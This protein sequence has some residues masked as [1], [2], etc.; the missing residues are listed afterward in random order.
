MA[1]SVLS[2]RR[3][4][5]ARRSLRTRSL[6]FW[7]VAR[8]KYLEKV[9]S[10]IPTRGNRYAHEVAQDDLF[11]QLLL[12]CM[13]GEATPTLQ[14]VP[15]IDLDEY[16]HTLIERFSNGHIRDTL[17]RLC[18]E[19][20]DRIPTWLL[21]VIRINLAQGGEVR[22]ST[23]MRSLNGRSLRETAL[24]TLPIVT[25]AVCAMDMY[26]VL[27][28]PQGQVFFLVSSMTAMIFGVAAF[29]SASVG[30]KHPRGGGTAPAS[31]A[32]LSCS[33]EELTYGF[34]TRHL[35]GGVN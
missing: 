7:P 10:G 1:L 25:G 18:A 17:V 29:S 4:A 8:L 12:D 31:K 15:G 35:E 26:G 16:K 33:P 21:P 5:W 22:R 34:V 23:G 28:D 32:T 13:D 19:S 3:R 20:S 11:A 27:V 6:K 2:S 24:R 14:P 9:G 30:L